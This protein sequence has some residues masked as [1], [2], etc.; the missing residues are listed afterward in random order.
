MIPGV[1]SRIGHGEGG[2]VDLVVVDGRFRRGHLEGL[3]DHRG[4]RGQVPARESGRD[5]SARHRDREHARDRRDA[6]HGDADRTRRDLHRS[7]LAVGI[8]HHARTTQS[9]RPGPIRDRLGVGVDLRS[10]LRQQLFQSVDRCGL[11]PPQPVE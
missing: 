1:E 8:R 10:P 3:R 11:T 6:R 2:V 4:D 9:P 5:A 7:L